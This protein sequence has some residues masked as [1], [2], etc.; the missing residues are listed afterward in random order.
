MNADFNASLNILAFGMGTIKTGR[1]EYTIPIIRN[2]YSMRCQ[3][4]TKSV[5]YLNGY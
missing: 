4:N 5:C 3:N 2:T 1:G